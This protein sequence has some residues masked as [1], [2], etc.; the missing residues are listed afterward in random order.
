MKTKRTYTVI[1][2]RMHFGDR[3]TDI[4]E[5]SGTLEELVNY[6][7]YTLQVGHSWNNR[8]S[9]QPKTVKSLISAL[10]RSYEYK[11]NGMTS[12]ELK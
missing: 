12:V 6:F 8:I 9:Q 4:S 3:P 1:I 11:N 5:V 10:N 2:S 7:G